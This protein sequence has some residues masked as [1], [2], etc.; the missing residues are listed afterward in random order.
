MNHAI[1]ISGVPNI[2]LT[3]KLVRNRTFKPGW[4]TDYLIGWNIMCVLIFAY[5]LFN[6]LHVLIF[7][8]A[9]FETLIYSM[10]KTRDMIF[11]FF[12]FSVRHFDILVPF[13]HILSLLVLRKNYARECFNHFYKIK[14]RKSVKKPSQKFKENKNCDLSFSKICTKEFIF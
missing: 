3:E 6:F 12:G 2:Y 7:T 1:R 9:V 13:L 8:H 14:I 11:R 5:A 10:E 4:W